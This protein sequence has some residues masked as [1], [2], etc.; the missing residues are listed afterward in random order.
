[1]SEAQGTPRRAN[2]VTTTSWEV[3]CVGKSNGAKVG[4][5]ETLFLAC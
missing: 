3:D 5:Y 1:M 4:N 2:G